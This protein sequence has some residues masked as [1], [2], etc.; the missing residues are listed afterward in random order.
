VSEQ[1]C[2]GCRARDAV[3]AELTR[4]LTR[5]EE[6]VRELKARLGTNSN[7]SS[8][9]P[10]ANP[11]HAPKPPAKPPTGRQA[12]GQPGHEGHARARLPAHRVNQVVPYVP[13]VCD[14]CRAPLAADPGPDDPAATWHQVAEL[15][16]VAAIVT[17]HQGH[18]RTCRGCGH[19]TR[20]SIPAQVCAHGYGP[21]LA[22]AVVFLSGRCHGSKR[23]VSEIVEVLFSVPLSAASVC[24]LEYQAAQALAP[25]HAQ[26]QQAVRAA[27]VKNTD[28]TGW[29][30]AGKLC[31]LW[32]AATESVAF[33]KICTGRGRA[34]LQELLGQRVHGI[35]CSDRW[36]AYGIVDLM[37]RQLCWAHLKRD[38][39]K[40]LE[41]GGEGAAV[42]Q[43]GLEAVKGVFGRWWDFRQ[44]LIDRATLRARLEPICADLQAA[45]QA[46]QDCPDKQVR[47]FCRNILELYP[48]LWT[49]A[50]VEGVD[51]TN[52]HA[53]RLLR[54]AVL[55]R[56]NSFGNHSSDG[57]RFT[58]RIL[59]VVQTLRLQERNVMD[60]LQQALAASRT[61][62]PIPTLVT[63]GV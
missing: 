59:T 51:P 50:Q 16:A 48:A 25:A 27:P 18:A 49:F 45:L 44:G 23:L 42:G 63:G 54:P 5:L 41:R 43:A 10:S 13:E 47:R 39:Q 55:W 9:P 26:A 35:L 21:R 3:I 60:Y 56:K 17:E 30:Q 58:E 53:E 34:S 31:W 32:M 52:N 38:F 57:C 4:R 33:F 6:E 40:W 8:L 19:V 62:Q 28:E 46:G 15:P 20:A 37:K 22:A 14:R 2:P 12:G 36:G 1:E 61:G 7:N 11:P 24:R 29:S